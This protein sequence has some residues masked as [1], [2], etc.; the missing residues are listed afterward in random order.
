MAIIT[1]VLLI[2]LIAAFFALIMKN[3]EIKTNR[4]SLKKTFQE[5]AEL[6]GQRFPVSLAFVAFFTALLF[7]VANFGTELFGYRI[8]FFSIGSIFISIAII[9]VLEDFYIYLKANTL[10]IL[11]VV[12]WAIY[13]FL[14][15][16]DDSNLS[17]GKTIEAFVI[18]STI[19]V[20]IFFVNFLGKN[21]DDAFWNFT[22]KTVFLVGIGTLFCGILYGGL[23]VA[24]I[25]LN[26]LFSA[27]IQIEVFINMAIICFLL[28][29]VYSLLI[30]PNKEEKYE[31]KL[32][33]TKI[34]KFLSLYILMPIL[35]I[36][37]LILYVYLLKIIILWEL[38]DGNVSWLVTTLAFGGLAVITLLYPIRKHENDKY[39]NFVMRWFSVLIFPLLT[40]MTVGIFR[41]ISDYGITI[42]RGY[43]LLG[44]VW[45]YG[46]YIYLFITKSRHIKWIFISPVILIFLAS[47]NLWGVAKIT[48]K[49]LTNEINAVLNEKVSFEEVAEILSQMPEEKLERT[50]SILEYLHK[51][52]GYQS[53]QAFFTEPVPQ[54]S[55]KFMDEFYD[56]ESEIKDKAQEFYFYGFHQDNLIVKDFNTFI[57]LKYSCYWNSDTSPYID[58]DTL[59][60]P[61]DDV[62]LNIPVRDIVSAYQANEAPQDGKAFE[63]STDYLLVEADN[64]RFQVY[65]FRAD[66]YKA[67]DSIDVS[68]IKGYVFCKN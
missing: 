38:P 10:S 15:P 36:Y 7:I 63:K 22:G 29:A 53:V 21:K 1:F 68:H 9:L 28:L 5:K 64:Y 51:N 62:F 6:M 32:Y 11:G 52:Y 37:T 65:E 3:R 57:D 35:A 20:S 49:S 48:E 56:I 24:L 60:I 13:C 16:A 61:I 55:W 45:F 54:D 43:L 19:I 58:N 12:L 59:K 40:L 26:L 23:S 25:A 50:K 4:F 31:P 42:K 2:F 34:Q 18:L 44:N 46:I 39:V 17:L 14:L 41:R 8:M 27:D 67:K 33:P 30:V 66:Y 47:I